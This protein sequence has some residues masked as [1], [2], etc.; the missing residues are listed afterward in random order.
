[1]FNYSKRSKWSNGS[2]EARGII[3]AKLAFPT[4]GQL[5]ESRV[6]LIQPDRKGHAPQIE[7]GETQHTTIN[8]S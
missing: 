1:M 2:D 7:M 8:S 3:R 5:S 6:I 4:S